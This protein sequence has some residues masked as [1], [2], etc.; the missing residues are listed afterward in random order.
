[1]HTKKSFHDFTQEK[2]LIVKK[3]ESTLFAE[4]WVLFAL[5]YIVSMEEILL[6]T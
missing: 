3:S 5:K 1:M 2:K 6:K 4:V